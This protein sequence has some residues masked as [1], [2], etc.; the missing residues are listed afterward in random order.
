L[1]GQL[2][3]HSYH[4][5]ALVQLSN[6][7]LDSIFGEEIET[8]ATLKAKLFQASIFFMNQFSCLSS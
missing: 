1:A 3:G 6:I 4:V 7:N 2:F 5:A 8:K